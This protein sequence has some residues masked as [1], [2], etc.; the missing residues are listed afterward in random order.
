MVHRFLITGSWFGSNGYLRGNK[1]KLCQF[2]LNKGFR[3]KN[4]HNRI[5]HNRFLCETANLFSFEVFAEK[6]WSFEVSS[7]LRGKI[8]FFEQRWV[9]QRRKIKIHMPKKI[10]MRRGSRKFIVYLGENVNQKFFKSG[11]YRESPCI[12]VLYFLG[13]SKNWIFIIFI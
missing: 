12:K 3:N 4:D 5:E 6:L 9:I 10:L 1:A 13:N 7:F 2:F 11:L 8:L